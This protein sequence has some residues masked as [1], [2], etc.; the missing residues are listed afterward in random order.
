MN[1]EILLLAATCTFLASLPTAMANDVATTI[2]MVRVPGG[3]FQMGTAT[4]EIHERPVHEVCVDSFEI[5][6]YEVTQAQWQA[7]M[8]S[9]GSK[10]AACGDN[11][12]VDQISWNQAQEFIH[13]LNAAGRGTFRLPTEAEWE[14][15]CRSG[16]KNEVWP[17]GVTAAY[18][19]DVAWFDKEAAGNQ[20]HPVGTKK[21][22][23][24]GIH[25]MAGNVWE[26]VQ[27]KFV[28][29]YPTAVAKNPRIESGG[30][31]KRVMRGGSWAQKLNYVRCG[32]RSRYEPEF[33][34]HLGRVGM[35]VVREIS[36]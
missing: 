1:R 30:E 12:P 31:E 17:G 11:C 24:L 33:V 6:K 15:A 14:Y 4:Y 25:D 9:K 36:H 27:D 10:F 21:P 28:T 23:G 8:D 16:G 3:C 2:E 20:T 35:R 5:G 7:V 34:D 22:N 13:K 18:V 26:W 29:P 32:I 19:Y